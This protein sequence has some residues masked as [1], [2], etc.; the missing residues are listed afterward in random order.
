[1]SRG[2]GQA[3]PE[4]WL[5]LGVGTGRRSGNFP[6]LGSIGRMCLKTEVGCRGCWARCLSAGLSRLPRAR[7]ERST[8]ISRSAH[9]LPRPERLKRAGVED[10]LAGGP[11]ANARTRRSCLPNPLRAV[12][13]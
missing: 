13:S 3:L 5:P 4:D 1:M 7:E 11:G 10:V 9:P 8:R 12:S 2:W 6:G